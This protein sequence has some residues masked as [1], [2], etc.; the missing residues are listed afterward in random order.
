LRLT[1]FPLG[2]NQLHQV[3][4]PGMIRRRTSRQLGK[5]STV[6]DVAR[7]AIQQIQ[8]VL[9]QGFATSPRLGRERATGGLRD[10]AN[11]ESNH[12]RHL[13]THRFRLAGVSDQRS[14]SN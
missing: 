3:D 6:I 7:L 12:E 8:E 4:R 10:A 5:E 2:A 11:L 13:A 1:A 9:L 14:N